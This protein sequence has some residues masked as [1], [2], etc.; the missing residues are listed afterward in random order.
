MR[1]ELES[2]RHAQRLAALNAAADAA[3]GRFLQCARTIE[4]EHGIDLSQWA[5]QPETGALARI[6]GD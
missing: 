1:W 2:L 4:K 3:N 6:G 5:Y